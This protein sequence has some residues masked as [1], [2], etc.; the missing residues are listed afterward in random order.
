[1]NNSLTKLDLS[2]LC[3]VTVQVIWPH[4]GYCLL[5][6]SN[7]VGPVSMKARV[8]CELSGQLNKERA[9]SLHVG[10]LLPELHDVKQ[11]YCLKMHPIPQCT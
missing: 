10:H 6:G 3:S 5:Q 8:S 2:L 7:S 11:K 4:W 9:S 1:M